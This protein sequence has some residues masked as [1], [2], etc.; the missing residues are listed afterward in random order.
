MSSLPVIYKFELDDEI[1]YQTPRGKLKVFKYGRQLW[2]RN[3]SPKRIQC[4]FRDGVK[5]R[6]PTIAEWMDYS[7]KKY[8][9]SEKIEEA[10][11]LPNPFL[12]LVRKSEF[13][14]KVVDKPV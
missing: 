14:G 6:R 13:V 7:L 5:Y 3:K 8:Y 10:L 11:N 2:Y 1:H 12:R 4:V 9:T